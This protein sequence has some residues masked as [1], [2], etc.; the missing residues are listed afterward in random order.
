[1][2]SKKQFGQFFKYSQFSTRIL[3]KKQST[4]YNVDSMLHIPEPEYDVDYI[5]NPSNRDIIYN[6]I[7]ARKTT[8]NIDK[9]LE[10]SKKPELRKLFLNELNKIPNQIDPI[11]L[12]YGTEPKILKECGHKPE[13]DFESQEFSTIVTK[14]KAFKS[15]ILKPLIGQRGYLFL[16]DLA[17][18]EEALIYYTI[19]KLMKY[20]FKLVSV[21]D[22]VPTEIIE[23]CGLILDNKKNLVYNLSPFYGDYSLSGT[24][25]M[26]LAHKV[27]NTTFD[28]EDLPLKMAAVS[29][30]F[31]AEISNLHEEKGLYRVHQFTKVEMFVCSKHEESANQFQELQNIQE[32]LFSSLNLHFR[33][34]DMPSHELGSPAYRKIDIEGWMPGRKMYGELSSC[35]NCTDY[36]SRRL[37]I[38][39]KTKN[40]EILYVH[41]LNGTAC[42]IPRMLIALCESY[43]TKH[44]RITVPNI[45]APYM[46]EKTLIRKQKIADTKLHKFKI[47]N[48]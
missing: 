41:T 6:N 11:V 44:G 24:A 25:E 30:C 14:L 22:I 5:C 13:F 34:I 42:A 39:Y 17:E 27:M 23:R 29:R 31:R 46:T 3:L 40:G 10:F 36:Q 7:L 37:G 26:S 18:L 35:S 33:I 1:M 32:N 48:L 20:N 45:L 43:Q 15:N 21:P 9:V 4:Q 19:K 8:G 16:G 28:S 2:W 47:F 12:S 38:K